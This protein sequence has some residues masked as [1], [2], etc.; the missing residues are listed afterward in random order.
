MIQL[1]VES[2]SPRK[3]YGPS[4]GNEPITIGRAEGNLLRLEEPHISSHHALITATP[5]GYILRDLQSTNGSSLIRSDQRTV[6]EAANNWEVLLQNNDRLFLGDYHAP[7]VILLEI[8]E[9]S[10]ETSP[11]T[12]HDGTIIATKPLQSTQVISREL[13]SDTVALAVLYRLSLGLNKEL[14]EEKVYDSLVNSLFEV[15]PPI[16]HISL[17]LR[18]D[19]SHGF[20]TRLVVSRQNRQRPGDPGQPNM[21]WSIIRTMLERAEAILF[22]DALE[23]FGSGETL[24]SSKIHS[25]ICVPLWINGEI[26]GVL[27]IDNREKKR[28]FSEQDLKIFLVYANQVSVILDNIRLHRALRLAEEKLKG[29]NIYLKRRRQKTYEVEGII[30]N[31]PAM[32]K[33]FDDLKQIA[34][35]KTTVLILGETGTG[36]EPVAHALHLMGDR[37]NEAFTSVN[38]TDLTETLLESELFGHRK[39]AFTEAKENKKGLFE[40]SDGGTIFLDEIGDAPKSLQSKL[41]RVIETGEFRPVGDTQVKRV[42]VRIITATNR[43]LKKEVEQAN[44]REDLYWRLNVFPIRIPPL[45]ERKE[46]IDLLAYHFLENFTRAMGKKIEQIADEALRLLKRHNYPGNVRE[47]RNII[48]R[49]VVRVPNDMTIIS[50]EF[51]PEEL[52][53]SRPLPLADSLENEERLPLGEFLE[54]SKRNFIARSLERHGWNITKTALQLDVSRVGLQN[55]VK[56]LG[57]KRPGS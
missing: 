21:S 16:T 45:R 29:E 24:L 44:F 4:Q 18:S 8:L 56:D 10:R 40:I 9:T 23:E 48:E 27:Q 12:F 37:R 43:D 30:G 34:Q 17:L 6:L 28:Q 39:G 38:C 3:T 2:G 55:M 15:F 11:R 46:D 31:S 51:V 33:I 22:E 14:D 42:D 53:E 50:A 36:K 26:G 54:R 20:E 5:R 52:H 32:Q 57:L 1:T 47:L 25:G 41:L 19:V 49:M 7:V 13:E 35:T